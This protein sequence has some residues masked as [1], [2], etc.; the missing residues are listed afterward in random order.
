MSVFLTGFSWVP[1]VSLGECRGSIFKETTTDS[2]HILACSSWS[3]SHLNWL[4]IGLTYVVKTLSLSNFFFVSWF[5]LRRF[6]NCLR[7]ILSNWIMRVHKEMGKSH[8][9]LQVTI[10]AFAAR[11]RK[12]T[13]NFSQDRRQRNGSINETE[14]DDFRNRVTALDHSVVYKI[15]DWMYFIY[16]ISTSSSMTEIEPQSPI[17]RRIWS[18]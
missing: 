4:C 5:I 8:S 12:T 11:P 14:I 2:F 13:K 7:F 16:Y 6:L 1:Q 9:L 10:S 18:L 17:L 15:W 3:S